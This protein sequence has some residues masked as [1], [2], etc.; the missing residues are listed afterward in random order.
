[1]TRT[2]HTISAEDLDAFARRLTELPERP[3]ETYN[4]REAVELVQSAIRDAMR[5]GYT[6]LQIA[7]LL[8]EYGLE[9]APSTITSILR[10]LSPTATARGSKHVLSKPKVAPSGSGTTDPATVPGSKPASAFAAP[11][12]EHAMHPDGL[13]VGL[14]GT[15]DV[16]RQMNMEMAGTRNSSE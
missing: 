3:K 14:S 5:K 15:P 1:M 8:K 9:A 4:T 16:L 6:V 7:E 13:L 2:S 10:R 11:V 12:H